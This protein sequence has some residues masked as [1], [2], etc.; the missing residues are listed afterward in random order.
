[1]SAS[2]QSTAPTTVTA[3]FWLWIASVVV[4]AIAVILAFANGQYEMAD[5]G[6]DAQIA[7]TVAPIAGIAGLV[8]GG[9]LRILF[10]VFMLRGRNWARIVL[11]IL[12]VITAIAGFA[13]VA[14]GGILELV[15]TLVTIVAAVLMY[16]P[17]S[18]AY[19]R[20]R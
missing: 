13:A 9:G 2:A 15:A 7:R 16:L 17:A 18:N 3:S 20:K 1:M 12:A 11:L 14:T 4:S 6:A 5:A 10:A 19:F 8:I